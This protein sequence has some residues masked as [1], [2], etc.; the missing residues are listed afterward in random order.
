MVK[1][2][3]KIGFVKR[4]VIHNLPSQFILQFGRV[5]TVSECC[6]ELWRLKFK[7]D[8]KLE[9]GQVKSLVVTGLKS[10]NQTD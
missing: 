1:I 3:C 5:Q 4:P 2:V 7:D 6:S 9:N 8:E 10:F